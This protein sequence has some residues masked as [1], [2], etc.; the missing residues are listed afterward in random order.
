MA[1]EANGRFTYSDVLHG[2]LLTSRKVLIFFSA[3]GSLLV[4]IGILQ[5]YSVTSLRIDGV[6]AIALGLLLNVFIWGAILFRCYQV[7]R[8]SP[9]LQGPVKF[10]FDEQG[11]VINGPHARGEVKW[12]A[13]LKW[14]EG[15]HAFL[16]F[17][18]PV[19]ASVV[20]KGFFSSPSDIT[21]LRALLQ[22]KVAAKR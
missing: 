6:R 2:A 3:F 8:K 21:S 5:M 4:A 18:H 7:W 20:P 10:E 1:I 15:K 14:K 16:L 11:Y 19:M 12:S 13:L 22:A 17:T 9:N